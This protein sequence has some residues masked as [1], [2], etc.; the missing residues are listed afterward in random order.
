MSTR[1]NNLIAEQRRQDVVALFR[2]GLDAHTIGERIG[3]KPSRVRE[4]VRRETLRL[5]RLVREMDTNFRPKAKKPTVYL[6][7][8]D[9][10]PFFESNDDRKQR[11][12]AVIG[13]RD[14][15][16]ALW[17]YLDKHDPAQARE[18]RRKWA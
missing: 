13:S 2:E 12:M 1:P 14:L 7:T 8:P 5:S 10:S 6:D 17:R 11:E 16:D 9:A 4:I 15:R 18:L 3:L